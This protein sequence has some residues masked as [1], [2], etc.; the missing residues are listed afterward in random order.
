MDSELTSVVVPLNT[1]G[2]LWELAQL[3]TRDR[4]VGL[5]ERGMT[6]AR[7]DLL[8]QVLMAGEP[9]TLRELAD[10]L[11][12]TPRNVTGLVDALAADDYLRRTPH[13]TD[14]RATLVELTD[15]GRE[16]VQAMSDG[17]ARLSGELLGDLSEAELTTFD[18]TLTR[19]LTRAR[20]VLDPGPG[21][22]GGDVP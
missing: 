20:A 19:I 13:P 17:A 3:F 9:P 8:L 22:A 21:P 11:K 12:V 1:L 7:G 4:A 18:A 15:R 16:T 10:A 5:A 2:R 14:R 6:R